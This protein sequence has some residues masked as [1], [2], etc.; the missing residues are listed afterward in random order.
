[1]RVNRVSITRG[2]TIK[3]YYSPLTDKDGVVINIRS[4]ATATQGVALDKERDHGIAV[5]MKC[6]ANP[7]WVQFIYREVIKPDNAQVPLGDESNPFGKLL[8]NSDLTVGCCASVPLDP[9]NSLMI[10]YDLTTSK[11]DIHWSPDGRETSGENGPGNPFY[12]AGHS[13]E[14]DCDSLTLFDRPEMDKKNLVSN[15]VA[16]AVIRDYAICNGAVK[17][18][19]TWI[20]DQTLDPQSPTQSRWNYNAW[21]MPASKIPDYFLCLLKK[22]YPLPAGQSTSSGVDC[23]HL[24]SASVNH[25]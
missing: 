23:T 20:S 25:P 5:R 1:M 15:R 19:V 4:D 2:T 22:Y 7:H 10:K 6:S 13:A 8:Q 16:R 21:I 17:A 11:D 24:P 3:T 9:D 14:R 12:E 18:Q